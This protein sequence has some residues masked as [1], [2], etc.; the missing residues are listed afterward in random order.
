MSIARL[1]V[2]TERLDL[3]A[4][5]GAVSP[6]A[7]AD[8]EGTGAIASFLGLVREHNLGRRVVKLEYEAYEPLAVRAFE[9]IADEIAE[10]W[11]AAQVAVHHRVGVLAVGEASVA[12][13]AASPHRADAFAA[14]R[15]LIERIKQIAPIWKREFF[16]GGD[17]WI[18]GATADPDDAAAREDAYRRACV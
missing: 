10:R 15:Y 1:A 14:C 8:A 7:E 18:E 9:R 3:D 11:P 17:V 12:I 4:L 2:T 16:D 6:A 5:I 13:T